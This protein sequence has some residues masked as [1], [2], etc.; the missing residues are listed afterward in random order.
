[1]ARLE[2]T[3][4]RSEA[5]ALILENNL[6]KSLAPKYNILFRDDKSYPYLMI[7]GHDYP[8]LAYYRGEPKRPHQFFGP[9]PNS[10]AVRES[11]QILQKVFRL[12]TC[13]DAVFANRS[14]PCLLYQIKR[15]SAPCVGHIGQDDYRR[16]VSSAVAFLQGKQSELIDA[17]TDRMMAASQAMEFEQAAELRDQIQARHACR[18]SSLFPAIP[19]SSMPMWW[20]FS[21]RPVWCAS[22]W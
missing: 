17:L 20:P 22:I 14:R 5:E 21:K 19:A 15:C 4:T 8:Q 12:R 18:K 1:M 11:I 13:E 16:D 3:V 7:S 10:Y 9:F 2:T 6:I